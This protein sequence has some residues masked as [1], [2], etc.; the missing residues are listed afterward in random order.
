[1]DRDAY[2]SAPAREPGCQVGQHDGCA[3]ANARDR[4]EVSALDAPM[5]GLD[6]L[7]TECLL[8]QGVMQLHDHRIALREQGIKQ[9]LRADQK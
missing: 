3:S 2:R 8:E 1:M 4:R 6:R 7:V 9:R 5:R